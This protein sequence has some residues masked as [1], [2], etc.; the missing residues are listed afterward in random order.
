[1]RD[2]GRGTNANAVIQALASD[3]IDGV[4]EGNGGPR[5]DR[6]LAAVTNVVAAQVLLE[7]MANELHVNGAD[8]TE[9]MRDA[10]RLVAPGA[11]ETALDNLGVTEHMIEQA[12]N[13]LSAAYA[14]SADP[15]IY[16]LMGTVSGMQAG[17]DASLVRTLLPN[18]Y[19]GTL[20]AAINKAAT[21]DQSVVATINNVVRDGTVP[22]ENVNRAPTISGQPPTSVKAGST[23]DF[24]PT[25]SDLDGDP[26]TFS[27]QGKPG[28][29]KFD[30]TSG[31][32]Y[33]TPQSG[34]ARRYDGIRIT[35]FDGELEASIGPFSIEVTMSNSNSGPSISGSPD[36]T[37]SVGETY[38]F[39]PAANDPDGDTLQF[40]ISGKPDWADFNTR[41]GRLSGTPGDGDVGLYRGIEITVTD[42]TMRDSL[43]AFSIEVVAAA[44][45]TGSV[46][47]DW[48]PP[49]QNEDG[50]QLMDLAGYRV[51]WARRGADYGPP[52]EINNPSVTRYI[53]DNLAPGTYDFATTAVNKKGIES[54]FSNEVTKTIR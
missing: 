23:Y 43:A 2:A 46:T 34:D 12:M 19:H 50:S 45:S 6:R 31:R 41:N 22:E 52:V 15:R 8:A 1:M 26:L 9:A 7:A 10:I 54:T 35:A 25:A 39:T 24:R 3:L 33:G 14:I 17:M 16:D 51:Y 13:G 30:D 4:I 47:L 48:T 36:G 29:A 20:S 21:G 37:V 49:S 53:V 5:S 44:S 11:D 27:I 40:E 32:L 18:D 28:W 38:T 42:G